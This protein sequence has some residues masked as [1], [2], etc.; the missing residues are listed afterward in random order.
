MKMVR[1]EGRLQKRLLNNIHNSGPR[2]QT[3]L[4]AAL[5]FGLGFN[6]TACL[7]CWWLVRLIYRRVCFGVA[8]LCCLD[9]FSR[10]PSTEHEKQNKHGSLINSNNISPGFR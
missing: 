8:F 7:H 5:V 4:Q 2:S 10:M 3:N 9:V 6:T 1:T